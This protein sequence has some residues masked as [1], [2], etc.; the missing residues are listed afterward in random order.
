MDPHNSKYPNPKEYPPGSIELSN[1]LDNFDLEDSIH[2]S[3]CPLPL[4]SRYHKINNSL[5][6]ASRID[7]ILIHHTLANLP[8]DYVAVETPISDHKLIGLTIGHPNP[9]E[10]SSWNKILPSKTRLNFFKEIINNAIGSKSI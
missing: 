4:M 9:P 7:F 6:S 3:L 8:K 2:D 10:N 5:I 1:I